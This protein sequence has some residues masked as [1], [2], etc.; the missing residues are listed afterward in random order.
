MSMKSVL[1]IALVGVVTLAVAPSLWDGWTVYSGGPPVIEC[2]GVT[3]E[4]CDEAF[5]DALA[6]LEDR[7]GRIGP[8][9]QFTFHSFN[10]RTC[11]DWVITWVISTF[12]PFARIEGLIAQPL[13]G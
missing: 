11:G 3:P 7:E 4:I 5:R 12:G 6:E 1:A 10:G 2:S 9:T 13:C 8:I